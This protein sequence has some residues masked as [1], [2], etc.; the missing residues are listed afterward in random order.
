M[1]ELAILAIV[2]GRVVS[3]LVVDGS[4]AVRG[5]TSPRRTEAIERA[6]AVRKAAES[7]AKRTGKPHPPEDRP[8]LAYLREL[9]RDAWIAARAKHIKKRTERAARPDTGP[10]SFRRY[11]AGL[12]SDAW[13]A[14][15]RKWDQLE[16]KR[17]A[18]VRPFEPDPTKPTVTVPGVVVDTDHVDDVKS[19]TTTEPDAPTTTPTKTPATEPATPT[20]GV[21]TVTTSPT[22]APSG[23]VAS[24]ADAINFCANG[25]SAASG[26]PSRIEHAIASLR[27]A[28]ADGPAIGH[29][30]T[31]SDAFQA[32]SAAMKAAHDELVA[33]T[34]VTDAY[35]GRPGAGDK[36]F[37][38]GG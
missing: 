8:A 18:K 5:K 32:A 14:W 35:S 27:A 37:V 31:A 21:T 29:L 26:M 4:Y 11:R 9:W 6:K 17:A 10:G 28:D 3:N 2:V 15:D 38:T 20:E 23:E 30:A 12:V 36:N 25:E 13:R 16:E 7:L 34:A 22:T 19:P 1:I 33:D 24:L